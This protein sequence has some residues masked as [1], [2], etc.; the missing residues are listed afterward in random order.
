VCS[1]IECVRKTGDPTKGELR[2]ESS[3]HLLENRRWVLKTVDLL[4]AQHPEHAV[5]RIFDAARSC[6]TSPFAA[7]IASGDRIDRALRVETDG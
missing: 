6:C 5:A 3:S 2:K 1:L 4:V 7:R